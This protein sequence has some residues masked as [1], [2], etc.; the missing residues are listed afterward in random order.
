M[1]WKKGLISVLLL[2]A[3]YGI[4]EEGIALSTLFNPSA[5]VVGG[6]GSYGHFMGVNTVWVPVVLMVHMVFS[7]GLPIFLLGMALPETRGKRLLTNRGITMAFAVL[8]TD[9]LVL[10]LFVYAAAHFWMGWPIFAGSFAAIAGLTLAAYRWPAESVMPTRPARPGG[11][12]PPA[13]M[14]VLL[15]VGVIFAQRLGESWGAPPFAVITVVIAVELAIG[16]YA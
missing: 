13:I 14:G 12:W 3:A 11:L 10:V 4:L 2:G 8:A 15:F 9:V 16:L 1:R 5:S 7:I 6:L